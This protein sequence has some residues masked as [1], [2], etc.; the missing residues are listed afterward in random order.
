MGTRIFNVT[1][2]E[3]KH[4]EFKEKSV[5]AKTAL[6]AVF[7]VLCTKCGASKTKDTVYITVRL[8]AEAD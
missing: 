4:V 7:N 6:D 1:W 5:I 2:R 8:E 3:K